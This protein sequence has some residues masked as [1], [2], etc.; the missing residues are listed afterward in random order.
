MRRFLSLA[1]GLLCL[2]SAHSQPIFYSL[3]G[4]NTTHFFAGQ[5]GTANSFLSPTDSIDVAGAT[6][7]CQGNSVLLTANFAPAGSSFQWQQSTDGGTTWTNVGANSST[8]IASATGLFNVIVTTAGVPTTY[9]YVSITVN[10]NP[11]AGFTFSPNNQCGSTPITFTNTSTGTGLSYLWNFGDPNSGVDSISTLTD[12]VHHFIGSSANGTQTFTVKLTVTNSNGCTN[13]YST[14]VTTVSPG[15]VLSGPTTSTY[16]GLTFFTQCSSLT[17]G[18]LTFFNT[19]TNIASN[20]NFTIVWG[21]NSSNYTSPTFPT[22][23]PVAHTYPIGTYDLLFI[24]TGSNGCIDTGLYHVFIGSNPGVGF[25]N[26]GNTTI[27]SGTSLTFDISGTGTNPPGTVY[28]VTFSDGT[29]PITYTHPAPANVSHVFNIGSCGYNVAGYN[30]SFSATIKASNP[31]LTSSVS[32]VPIYVSQRPSMGF[33][34]APRDTVCV[35]TVMQ[36]SNTSGNISDVIN[37]NCSTGKSV[38]TISP[39]TGWT[40][41]GGSLGT[42]NGVNLPNV[43]T[44]GTGSIFINYTVPGTYSIKLKGGNQNCGID[45]STRNVCI[46]PAPTSSFT[47]SGNTGCAPYTVTTTN[48]S[49]TPICG[50]NTYTWSV[51]YSNT[52]GCTPNSSGASFINGTTATS[53]TPEFQFT[54]PGV[55]T[56]TLVTKNS[57]GTCSA[58]SSQTV[59]VKAKPTASITAPAAVC[60]NGSIN[61]SATVLNC[62][63]T[64]AATYFWS[65]PGGIPSTSNSSNPGAITYNTSGLFTIS[66][67]VANE[68]GS[69]TITKPITVNVAPDV[70]VPSSQTFCTGTPTGAFSF[71]SAVAGTTYAWTNT[72]TA[73][74]LAASGNGTIAS[75]TASNPGAAPISGIITV[76][77][78]SGC[79]GPSQSFTITV[80]PRP[81]SPSVVTPVLYC[82][83]ETAV[84]LTGTAT[85]GSGNTVT[86]YNNAALNNGVTIAPIPSTTT[87]GS[88]TW[89][90]TQTNSYNCASA[91]ATIVVTVHPLIAGN[92]IGTDQSICT[93]TIPN[94]LTGQSAVGGGNGSY[95]YQWQVSTDGGV[96]WTIVS[97]ATLSSYAPGALSGNVKYRRVVNSST[98]SDTSN[99]VTIT[100]QGTLANIGIDSSQTIC[101]GTVPA[102]LFG[103]TPSGGSG[104]FNYQWESSPNNST[105]TIITGAT[106]A[107]YQPAA[108]TATTYYRRKTSSGSCSS[109]SPAVTI[110]VNPKPV[111][112]AIADAAYCNGT[113]I[114]NISFNST[115]ASNVSYSWTNDN[116]AIGLGANGTGALPS[117]TAT[118]TTNPKVPLSGNITVTPTYTGGGISCNGTPV[119]FKITI[120]PTITINPIA[121]A[122]VCTG[123]TIPSLTPVHDAGAFAGSAITYAWTVTGTGINLANGS[124]ASIPAYTALNAGTTDL[125][126]TITVTPKYSFGGK[127]CDGTPVAYTVSV[128]PGAPPAFAGVDTALC[129]ATTYTLQGNLPASTT[130]LWT[131]ISGPATSFVDPTIPNTQASG[132]APSNVYKFVWTITGFASCPPSKDTV[133][134]TVDPEVVNTIDTVTK[135]IC[136]GQTLT[137]TG[138]APSGGNG[139]YFYQ[140]QQ[141]PDNSSWTIM[142]GQ[143]TASLTI[144]PSASAYFKRVVTSLPCSKE[145]YSVHVSVQPALTNNTTS[146]NQSICINTAAA[147]LNGSLPAGGN[148]QFAYQWQ[149]STNGGAT[150]ANITSAT[151]QDYAPGVL[152]VTTKFRRQVN[153]ALCSGPQASTSNEITITVNPNAKALFSPAVTTG[154]APFN[155]TP[156]IINLQQFSLQNSQYAWYVNGNFIGNGST[157]PGYTMLNE[158]DS[159][160]VKLIAVSAFGCLNDS[161]SHKFYTYKVPHPSFTVSDTVGCGPLSILITNTT[162]DIGSFNY[163]WDF[164]NGQTSTAVQPGTIIFLPNTNKNDT[165]Y[166]VKLTIFSVCDTITISKSIRVK[167][168]PK[169]LFT[170]NATVGCSP[171]TVIFTNTSIG[172]GNT[173]TWHFDDGSAPFITNA[174][175][176]V[177]HTYSV[178]VRDTF[179]IKLVA[180][181]ECGKD[182]LTYAVVV[183]PNTIALDFAVN[184]NEQSG[185][186]PHTVRFINNSSGATHF[187]W[188]FNDGNLLSTTQNIDTITH[189]FLSPG[190]YVVSLH[191][192]NSCSD[193]TTTET[194]IVYPKPTAGFS[195]NVY[196]ACKGDTIQYNNLSTGATSYLWKFGDGNTSTLVNPK[197][198]YANPG[199]Y[200]VVLTAFR[201]NAPG[202]FCSDSSVT[203]VNIVS[204]LPGAF[205]ASDTVSY[206]APFT[207]NFTNLNVPSV[208]A[209]WDFGDGTFGSGN[210]TSHT[211]IQAGIYTVKLVVLV[212]GGCTYITNRTIKVLGPNGTLSYTSGYVCNNNTA[213]FQVQASNTDSIQWNFGDGILLTTTSNV[214]SHSYINGGIYIPSATLINTFG[215]HVPLTGV[216]TIKVDKIKAGFTS[217]QQQYCGYTAVNF[218]DTSHAYFGKAQ[219]KW[220]FGDGTFATGNPVLHNYTTT[221]SYTIQLIVFGNSG[222]SDTLIKQVNVQVKNMPVASITG[223]TLACTKAPLTFNANIQS[224]DALSLIKW[225]VSNG[226]TATGNQLVTTFT[227]PG[228]YTIQLIAG[229]ANGCYDTTYHTVRINPT[230]TV[231]ASNDVNLCR[232]NSVQLNAVGASQYSWS[233]LQGLSCTTCPNP[234]A[235]PVITTPY[236]VQGTNSFGCSGYDTVVV[237]VIQPLHLQLSS[238]DSICIGESTNLLAS[239]AT[240]YSWSPGAGLNNTTISNPTASPA[241]TT[242]YRVV[243]YDGFNCFTDT[244]FVTVAVGQYPTVNLGAD[245][246]LAAGTL[247]PLNAVVTNGPIQNWLWTP[248]TNLNCSNC[249]LPIATIK[250]D[251]TYSVKVTT[252]YG[253]TATDTVNIKVFCE[254]AQAFVPN[255]FTPDGDGVNDILM[256]RGKGIVMVKNFRIYNRWGEVVFE[257]SNFQPNDPA[258]GWNGKINNVVGGPD[259]YV[260]TADVICENGATFTYKGNVSILK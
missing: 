147:L 46:N 218:T 130:G 55:Y 256:V 140:W 50:A 95:N 251:I 165:T 72:N 10:P 229:T 172:F 182:S 78:T 217:A 134:I 175:G 184:G 45:S 123:T 66:L 194:I 260:Y 22:S 102:L 73:I 93:N 71:S 18:S 148:N 234:I 164:G 44:S 24:V 14:T 65:F 64:T 75:F 111:M 250:K 89:Y 126:A 245:L 248:A 117:F 3:A 137:L 257:K 77:P 20:T 19:S 213:F 8:Y 101:S 68:C 181:N 154:C 152:T 142:A 146:S 39:A 240:S 88:S 36:V 119:I 79:A 74:G 171:M 224:I 34:I 195:L 193:T 58:T 91:A 227:I 81:S 185:C 153:T 122:V 6:T 108:L 131:Q 253:C 150:W 113:L 133:T 43:W 139:I 174:A 103:Q 209:N 151:N 26:P 178:G 162:P 118:N 124:G 252:Y 112:N 204:T 135:T 166:I 210:T 244:A 155:L 192:T 200:T 104:S 173:Y 5:P 161:T 216:D 125:V 21:D 202:S 215:C 127:T 109:Y 132:L 163:N 114:N 141:S 212:P 226:V 205:T 63:A 136:F 156:T 219:V 190:T 11:V 222:C 116:T 170:P 249:S 7:F 145:S 42:D 231:I 228:I 82:L 60:Q 57:F 1:I 106:A 138:T 199:V 198:V 110:T 157:F 4:S 69:T 243:G 37:G 211:F 230:P 259:V 246:I 189:T 49:N 13:I 62:Y 48:N 236:V 16:N 206:C 241:V 90:V 38:W 23:S 144:S 203:Q 9:P 225:T 159:V 80:N 94:P 223:D 52:S 208:T 54:N 85:S 51:S 177:S 25:A 258:Y 96:T 196:T 97:G 160:L 28:T 169:V 207:V 191:A 238:S 87:A 56:I 107:D 129:A 221:G 35:N 168:K 176:T 214:I 92:N 47:L 12:P 33:A 143:T 40:L 99:Q 239:G 86:W 167:S 149:E 67:T 32:V 83:N 115:P 41:V 98:C 235:A 242:T 61:P 76:T 27:C 59:T 53:A 2:L 15:T 188:D 183:S 187:A 179:Y 255:A 30:N 31:C 233:P 17:T 220:D 201:F 237:T 84:P 247:Q 29:A 158:N 232:G 70:T 105:W 120:L 254:S 197:H 128:K 121:N 100:V 186:S 180:V